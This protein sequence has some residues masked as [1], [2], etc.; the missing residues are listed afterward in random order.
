MEMMHAIH[1]GDFEKAEEIRK[2]FLPLEDLR[3]GI[4][5]IR[6]LHHAVT[7]A[8]IGNMGP[9]QPFLSELTQDQISKIASAAKSL[10]QGGVV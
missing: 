10:M 8:G 6:V 5:P 3:N 4:H 2:W 1:S 9:L 7:E